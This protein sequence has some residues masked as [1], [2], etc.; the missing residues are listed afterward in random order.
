M[1]PVSIS[2]K[3]SKE[4]SIR[5]VIED[6]RKAGKHPACHGSRAECS[7]FG[8]SNQGAGAVRKKNLGMFEMSAQHHAPEPSW[9]DAWVAVR[10]RLRMELGQGVFDSWIGP[11]SLIA[12]ADG[13]VRLSSPSR[14]VRDYTASH[15]GER[16]EKA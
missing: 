12:A 4:G 11:L 5:T 6:A 3:G 2:R 1:A 10:D 14:L 15:H 16:I 13:V 7:L 9:T 8:Q